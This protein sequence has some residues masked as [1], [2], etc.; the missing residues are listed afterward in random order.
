M[1]KPKNVSAHLYDDG[2]GELHVWCVSFDIRGSIPRGA[3]GLADEAAI[4]RK[5][6]QIAKLIEQ[7]EIPED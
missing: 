7:L 3:N 1:S 6:K 4:R 5:Q 2:K